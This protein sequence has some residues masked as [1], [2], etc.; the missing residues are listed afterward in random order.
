MDVNPQCLN[1]LAF[2]L[3]RHMNDP[4]Y[5][6]IMMYGGSSSGKSYSAVQAILIQGFKEGSSTMVY[7]KVGASIE[8]SI[9][10]DFRRAAIQLDMDDF[11]EF[12]KRRIKYK[13]SGAV[14][15]FKG[16]D[17][18]EKI[19]GLSDF[20]RVYLDEWSEF[21]EADDDQMRLRL[22]GMEGQQIIYSWNPI[23]EQHW[24]K[25]NRIDNEEWDEIPSTLELFGEKIPEAITRVKSIKINRSR[26]MIN[27]K[28]GEEYVHESDAVLIQTTYL[29]N[30]WVVGSPDG[31]YGYYDDQAITHFENLRQKDPVQYQ[32]YALGEWGHISTGSEFFS[33][34]R[35]GTHTAKVSYNSSL[36]VHLSVDNNVLPYIT[37][38]FW[39]I[40]IAGETK[41]VTQFDELTA[42]PPDNTVRKA[43]RLVADRLRAVGCP[44]VFLHGD[45]STRAANTIDEEK[46]SFLDL[47]IDTL[48]KG[49]IEVEDKVGSRNPSVP[50][51][52]EF[53]NAIWEGVLSD[54]SI[55][56]AE[57]CRTS[58]DDY[59][60]VQKDVNGAILKARV[61]NKVT[62][63]TYEEHGHCS[64]TLRYAVCDLLEDE[65]TAFSN[66]RKRNLYA[67]DGAVSYY[68]PE[69]ACAYTDDI[70]YLHPYI[71]GKFVMVHCKLC[72][73]RWHV[74][75]A[76]FRET[77]STDEMCSLVKAEGADQIVV[78]C[79]QSHYSFVRDLR[80]KV[81]EVR[82]SKESTDIDRRVAATSDYVRT[83]ILFNAS[84]ADENPEYGL[85]MANLLDYN[86]D[87]KS[88]EASA[89]L[90]GFAKFAIKSHS[91]Q[92]EV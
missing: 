86:K 16:L 60:A 28:T 61:K 83:H 23:S 78:E 15:E 47:Y 48:Q 46:R 21:E 54:L 89:V 90:S 3:L 32:V 26:P 17:D 66:R 34:F 30:F 8:T 67:K 24:I 84:L 88:K 27:P 79:S 35:V 43:A 51:S 87:G 36:P 63:Q 82:I 75:S 76:C 71:C 14:I 80:D 22:R 92:E 20:K 12:K 40:D 38:T 7:R 13:H 44:K 73:Q 65:F 85:F 49:G 11:L 19:K 2:H 72:G 81:G 25:K 10:A 45:A 55:K 77:S 37:A 53:V 41:R 62:M 31:T 74:V 52:G 58:I 57:N 56:I 39:Q 6:Y 50:I 1:P 9:Y 42:T 18:P 33:S 91:M 70:L 59:Q 69:T 68:N 29:N 64:D 5:R 4:Q